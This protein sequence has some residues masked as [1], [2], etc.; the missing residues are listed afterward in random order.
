MSSQLRWGV[1]KYQDASSRMSPALLRARSRYTKRNIATGIVI[2]GI[3]VSIYAYAATATGSDDFSD[4]PMPPLPENA[5]EKL[6]R[7]RGGESRT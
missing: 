7:E 3:V 4:V 2:A 1:N 5:V 6:R